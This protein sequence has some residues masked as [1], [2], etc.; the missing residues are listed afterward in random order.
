ML[1]YKEVSIQQLFFISLFIIVN[2]DNKYKPYCKTYDIPVQN[3]ALKYGDTEDK[4]S[5][6]TGNLSLPANS[7][8]SQSLLFCLKWFIISNASFGCFPMLKCILP[9][10]GW[11]ALI[12]FGRNGALE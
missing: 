1:Q 7:T 12:G 4:T 10:I 3:I 9:S 2:N 6:C 8:T 5:L 11:E